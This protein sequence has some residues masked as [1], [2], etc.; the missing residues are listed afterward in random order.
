MKYAEGNARLADY[1]RQIT[2]IRSQ[3]RETRQAIEPQDVQDYEFARVEGPV[4]LSALFGAHDSLIV[5]HN[6]GT[7]C[8]YCTLWADGYN[9]IHRHVVTRAAFVVTSPDAPDVQERF[10]KG[11]GWAFPMVSH[12]GTTFAADMGYRSAN[13]RW[14]PG[15]SVFQRRGTGIARVSD[16]SE[17][18]YDDFCALWHLFDLLP[19]G[20]GDWAPR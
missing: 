10:A 19:G 20:P 14:Q 18:P 13:G 3:M 9:G 2:A 4:R 1:R 8:P 7:S 15:L 16:A 6:M 11:R 5:V 17:Q 12:R